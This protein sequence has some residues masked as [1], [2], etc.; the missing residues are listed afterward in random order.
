MAGVTALYVGLYLFFVPSGIVHPGE[1]PLMMVGYGMGA[2]FVALFMQVGPSTIG[3]MDMQTACA[4]RV[5]VW[6]VVT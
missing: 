2:S 1:V 4:I 3:R 6:S 5:F